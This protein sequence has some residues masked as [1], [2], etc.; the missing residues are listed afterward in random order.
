MSYYYLGPIT[1]NKKR[2]LGLTAE[3]PFADNLL[4][5]HKLQNN[6]LDDVSHNPVS[7]SDELL[8]E[9]S[10]GAFD[11]SESSSK[12]TGIPEEASASTS[13]RERHILASSPRPELDV[14]KSN[15]P[16]TSFFSRGRSSKTFGGQSFKRP[17]QAMNDGATDEDERTEQWSSNKPKMRRFYGRGRGI[18]SIRG[19]QA[20]IKEQPTKKTNGAGR[21][22]LGAQGDGGL[23]LQHKSGGNNG[24]AKL[25][26][27]SFELSRRRLKH[28]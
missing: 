5:M 18:D 2:M 16:S 24:R 10:D 6:T 26:Y 8:S 15:I 23:F 19:S 1:G 13:E 22:K 12:H 3:K 17:F 20:V 7:S 27:G 14:D 25:T 4:I 9:L 11:E 21:S 28:W